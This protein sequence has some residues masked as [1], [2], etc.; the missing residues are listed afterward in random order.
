MRCRSQR[1]ELFV[2]AYREF[3]N[4]AS[5]TLKSLTSFIDRLLATSS[6]YCGT[7]EKAGTDEYQG[8]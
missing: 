6:E 3:I 7:R 1:K 8:F 2:W 5:V 4:R